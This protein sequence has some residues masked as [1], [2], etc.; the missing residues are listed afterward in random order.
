MLKLKKGTTE[1]EILGQITF[2]PDEESLEQTNY[3]IVIDGVTTTI[4]SSDTDWEVIDAPDPEPVIE[5]TST[6]EPEP[7]LEPIPAPTQ[8]EQERDLWL[9]QFNLLQKSKRAK[10]QL[11]D[12]GLS[13]T[14]D[15]QAAFDALVAWV[16]DNRKTEYVNYL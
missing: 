1:Y 7:V 9:S 8:E 10:Q 12:V 15:E 4:E 2:K 6:P 5:E 11:E 16:A 3:T 14:P 13:F